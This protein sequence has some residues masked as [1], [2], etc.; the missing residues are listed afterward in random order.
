MTLK[1]AFTF[2]NWKY[3]YVHSH[4]SFVCGVW[5]VITDTALIA[6]GYVNIILIKSV[7]CMVFCLKSCS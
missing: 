3:Q 1:D 2:L 6:N 4:L 5:D 7:H